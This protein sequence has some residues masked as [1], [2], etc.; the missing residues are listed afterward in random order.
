[1]KS[2]THYLVKSG[3]NH[4]LFFIVAQGGVVFNLLIKF[5]ILLIDQLGMHL[6]NLELLKRQI[7][8][9][10]W[11]SEPTGRVM[12]IEPS[13][14]K[15]TIKRGIILYV[16]L[17][18]VA[19]PSGIC[20]NQTRLPDFKIPDLRQRTIA[21]FI[22]TRED[23]VI[24]VIEAPADLPEAEA[25]A[26]I[27]DVAETPPFHEQIMQAAEDY[28]V[29]PY[30]IKAVIQAESNYNPNAVSKRGAQGL[31]QLMPNTAKWLG[32]DD[33]FD[34]AL[35]I[36][37][38]VRYLRRLLDRFEGDEALALAAYNAGSRYVRKYKGVPP[39]RAT[40]IYIEKVFRYRFE[41]EEETI[42]SLAESF[43]DEEPAT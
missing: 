9:K 6:D 40:R 38:G 42:S 10:I 7:I 23:I 14:I 37:G 3:M 30:L 19:I 41:L 33:C 39:F 22:P 31:M 13:D 12:K 8:K 16:M 26:E 34:P 28:Q 32:V 17:A 27:A 2:I 1:M 36:D 18:M 4:I 20:S 11:K 15:Q 24:P 21:Y 43:N 5:S 25:E 35:N 29:D